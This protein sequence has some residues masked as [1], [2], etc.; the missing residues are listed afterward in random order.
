MI[1]PPLFRSRE[2][3]G[4]SRF[5]ARVF[6]LALA[7]AAVTSSLPLQA[8]AQTPNPSSWTGGSVSYGTLSISQSALRGE[9]SAQ[10]VS[11]SHSLPGYWGFGWEIY[12]CA[13]TTVAPS[14]AAGVP[15]SS[16]CTKI[17][18][19]T[20][21]D[22]GTQ[23]HATLTPSSQMISN[24][25]VVIV[26]YTPGTTEKIWAAWL[27]TTKAA[28]TSTSPSPL[29]ESGL[30]G[31]TV[32][33]T[34][35]HTTY[36]TSGLDKDDFEL[37]SAPDGVTISS[38]SR[39]SGTVAT[40]T[41][42]YDDSNDFDANEKLSVKVLDSGHAG[43]GDLTTAETDVTAVVETAPAAPGGLRATGANLRATLTWNNPQDPSITG[44]EVHRKLASVS[45][46]GSWTAIAGSGAATVTHTVRGLSNG[47][48]YDFQVRALRAKAPPGA[49]SARARAT[50]AAAAPPS[51]TVW[52]GIIPL[53]L[54]FSNAPNEWDVV[55]SSLAASPTSQ[56]IVLEYTGR[57]VRGWNTYV[58][59]ACP[60]RTVSLLTMPQ[61]RPSGCSMIT[62]PAAGHAANRFTATFSP[63]Q[64]MID[65]GG[66]VFVA[67]FDDHPHRYNMYAEWVPVSG[68]A[69]ITKTSPATLGEENLNGATVTVDL[70]GFTFQASVAAGDFELS[71][72]PSGAVVSVSTAARDATEADVA[73]LTLAY[74]GD[75]DEA[76]S[77]GVKAKASG[78]TGSSDLEAG[79]VRVAATV[80][81]A[82]PA[83]ADLVAAAGNASAIL[84]WTDPS[85]TKITGYE[86]QRREAGESWGTTWTAMTGSGAAT[87]RYVVAGLTNGQAYDFRI[88]AL[89]SKAPASEASEAASATPAAATASITAQSADPLTEANIGGATVTVTLERDTYVASGLD[90]D[91]FEL[92]SKPAGVTISSVSRTSGTVAVVTLAF[93]GDFDADA[94]LSVRVLASGLTGSSALTTATIDVTAVLELE[95]SI[96]A[97]SVDPLT[98]ANINEATITVTLTNTTYVASGL[99]EDDFELPSKPTG[100]TINDAIRLSVSDARLWLAFTDDFDADAT[101]SVK[102]LAS[103]H[104]K[105]GDL[106]TGTI[107]VTATVEPAAAKPTELSGRNGNRQVVLS[108]KNPGDETI[109]GYEYQRRESGESWGSWTAMMGSSA[110]TVS[111]AVTGLTNGQGYDF[112][113]RAL[114]TKADPSAASDAISETPTAA[115]ASIT[116]Q[117]P[118][119]EA[120]IGGATVTVTLTG[121]TYV[122]SGLDKNDFELPSKPGG[123]T[124]SAARRSS[125]AAA[126]LT[127]AYDNTDP[128]YDFDTGAKLSVKVLA[129]G[130]AGS[131]NI[132]TAQIDVT[133]VD[134]TAPVAPAGL[135]ATGWNTQVVLRWTNPS[136]ASITSWEYR[137]KLSSESD[138]SEWAAV[139]GSS[140]STTTAIVPNLINGNAYNFQVRAVAA[141]AP[142]GGAGAASAV[143]A[144]P[145]A[146]AVSAFITSPASLTEANLDG[147]TVTV[148]LAG[149]TY[150]AAS[151]LGADDFELASKPAGVTIKAT[152]GVSRSSDTA[153]VLT[154]AYDGTDP[155]YDFDTNEKLSVKVLDSG[156]AGSGNITTAQIDV[157]AVVETAPAAPADLTAAA[158]NFQATL[159]WT[160]PGNANITSWEYSKKLS[161]PSTR[162]WG[163]W[164]AMA[165]SGA[166]TTSYVVRGLSN[167]RAYDFRIRAV[168]AKAPDGGTASAT[169][170]ATPA[171]PAGPSATV[172]RLL[173]SSY[174]PHFHVDTASLAAT[175]SPQS[176]AFRLTSGG[177]WPQVDVYACAQTTVIVNG[178]RDGPVPSGCVLILDGPPNP[179]PNRDGPLTASLTLTQ[180]MIDNGGV[181]FLLRYNWSGWRQNHYAEWVPISAGASITGTSPASPGEGSLNGATVTVD[182]TGL[183]FNSGVAAGDFELS[184]VPSGAVVSV[185]GA[186]RHAT[187]T[188]VAV[189]TL[190][191]T[192]DYDEAFSL[193][194][195]AKAS[196]H[197]G[198]S[199]LKTGTVRVAATV[200]ERPAK[201]SGVTARGV[202]SGVLLKWTNPNNPDITSW[203][204]QQR[205]SGGSYGNTTAMTGSGASTT[206]YVV[207]GLT[208]GSAY[209]F[210]IRA[211][212]AKAP[213][214]G[215]SDWSD[216]VTATAEAE[217]ASIKS[218]TPSSLTEENLDDAE[219]TVE[220][221][222]GLDFDSDVAAADFELSGAPSGVSVSVSAVAWASSEADEAVLTLDYTTTGDFDSDFSLVVKAKATGHTG[223]SDLSAAGVAVA[224][225][226]E[227]APKKPGGLSARNGKWEVVLTWADP[228]NSKITSWQYRKKLSSVTGW[229][230][231]ADVS[232]SSAT[233]TT[234]T[235]TGLTNGTTY[236]FQVRAVAAKAPDGAASITVSGT[237]STVLA[238]LAFTDPRFPTEENLDGAKIEVNLGDSQYVASGLDK[239]DFQLASK[240]PGVTIRDVERSSGTEA[241][242]QLSY[243]GSEFDTDQK[244]SVR[245]LA[246]GHAGTENIVTGETSVTAVVEETP[247]KPTGLTAA[248][249]DGEAVLRWTG[250]ENPKITSWEYRKKLSSGSVWEGW[251][252]VASS[253]ATTRT[254]TVPGLTNGSA[255]DFQVRALRTK[256]PAAGIASD[257]AT[258]TPTAPGAAISS[259]DPS[260]LTEE[261][262][263]GAEVT[264]SLSNTTYV[265][266]GTLV[267][268]HFELP[269]K[270]TGVTISGV[271]RS[272]DTAAVVTLAYDGTDF[273][274]D[275]KLSVKVLAAG[276]AKTGDLT[277]PEVDVTAAAGAEVNGVS[278]TSTPSGGSSGDTYGPGEEIR[279][280]VSFTD[281]RLRVT[282]ATSEG[283]PYVELGVGSA[284]RRAVYDSSASS[285]GRLAFGYTVQSGDSDANGISIGSGALKANT[286]SIGTGRGPR[287]TPAGLSLLG[288]AVSDDSDHKVDGSLSVPAKPTVLSASAGVGEAVL[289]WTDPSDSGITGW[290]Y[291][292][293]SDGG[294]WSLWKAVTGGIA[295]TTSATVDGLTGGES[296]SFQVRAKNGDGAS[297]ASDATSSVT[298]LGMAIT[299][300][301]SPLAEHPVTLMD[302]AKITVTLKGAIEFNSSLAVGDFELVTDV[303]G[304]TISGAE[305][306][307]G[308]TKAAELTLAYD[309]TDFETDRKVSVKVKGS[310][311]G[312]TAE[313]TTTTEFPVTATDEAPP[314]AITG[315][316][317]YPRDGVVVLTWT[318][319]SDTA[320]SYEYRHRKT[321]DSWPASW[322]ALAR[323]ASNT[324]RV[325][326]L[327]N[328]SAYE[329]EFR[330]VTDRGGAGASVSVTAT[331]NPVSATITGTSPATVTD[332]DLDGATVTVGVTGT[333]FNSSITK[334]DFEVSGITGLGIKASGGVNRSSDTEAVL[335]LAYSGTGLSADGAFTVKVAHGSHL[336]G[337]NLTAGTVTVRAVPE[338]SGVSFTG[339]PP[340]NSTWRRGEKIVVDVEFSPGVTV[341]GTPQLGLGIGSNTRQAAYESSGS[342]ST[343]LRFGYVVQ[344]ADED[345]DG[346][347]IAATALGL[348]GGSIVHSGAS[349]VNAALG[350]GTH[351]VTDDSDHKVDGSIAAYAI[352]VSPSGSLTLDEGGSG[353]T[354]DVNL[355]LQPVIDVVVDVSSD[356]ADV[357]VSKDGGTTKSSSVML[358][359]NT[360]SWNTAQ[361][362]TVYAGED[363][364]AGDDSATL[365]Y[366]VVAES[367][368]D[369]YDSAPD[370]TRAV[371]VTDDDE[372][373][374][375]TSKSSA[376][377]NESGSGNSFTYNVKL[378]SEPTGNVTVTPASSPAGLVTV[379][380]SRSDN[381]L[382]FTTTDWD[383][384]QEVTVTAVDNDV[385]DA[386]DRT[387]SVTHSVSG[388][389]YAT[390]ETLDS[391]SVT[392]TDKDTA[393][394]EVSAVSGQATEDGGTATFT[395][396]LATQP[397]AAVTM[398]VTSGDTG[399]GTVSPATLTFEVDDNNG[400]I[401]SDTQEVTVT[402]VDD[403]LVDGTQTYDITLGSPTSTDSKYSGL[404]S[405]TVS[406]TTTDDD[407]PAVVVSAVSGQA[408]EAGGTATFTVRLATQPTAAVTI[409]VSSGD[410]GEGTVSP[411]TLTFETDDTNSRIW[412]T[413]QTVTVTG[414]DDSLDDGDQS[415]D[416]TLGSPTSTDTGYSGLSAQTVSVTT[417][418]D[419]TAAVEVSVVS[420]Q[421]TEAGGT[422][423]FTVKLGSEPTADVTIAVSSGDVGEG[424]V[425]PA[426]LTFETDNTNSKIWSAAQTVTVTGIDDSLDDGD[427]SYDITLGSPTSTDAG[428]SGLSAQTVSVTTTDDDTAAVVVSAVSGQATEAGG[429]ATFTVK[430][431]S[432]PTADV[433]ITV[434][435]GDVGE[436]TVLPATLTFET[437]NDNSKIWSTAQT[438]TVTG[439]DD[440]LDDGDQSYDITLG[441]PTSSDAGY[442]GLSA[443]TVSVTT[444]DDDTAAVEV[445]AVSGQATEAGGTATFTVKLGSEP[446]ADVTIAVSSGDVGEG[447]VSPATLT[448]ETDDTNSRIWS[449]AQTVT[450]TG[451]DD[452]LDDGDRSYDITLGSPTST[453]TGYS[454]LSAQTVSVTTTDDDTAAVEVSAV[455]GQAT[456]AGGTATFTVKLGSEPA[457]NVTIAVSSGDVGEGTVSPA[458]L[459]FETDNTNSKIWSAAQT[460]TVTGVDDSLADGPQ[461]YDVT[462]GSPTSTDA[463][464][465]GLLA[466][467]VSVTTTDDDT[468]AVEVSAVSGQA[469]EAGGTATFTVKL[470]TQPTAD[471]TIA[472]SSGDVGEGTVSPATLTFETDDTNS[473]IWSTAQ[474]VTVT[475]VDD[476]LDDG[477]QSY[478]ITLGSPT[479]TDAGYSGL[480]AQTVSVTT[481]DD[482][483][484]AVEVSVVSGQATEAGGTATFTVKLGSEP[485]ADVTIAVSSGDVGEGTVSPATLT[486]ET[487]N[488]NSKIWSAAQTVTVTGIDDS[489]DD[490]DQSYDI[491]LGSPTST[492]TGYS[493]LSAQTVSVT[494]TDDDTAAVEVSVV[495]GQ[496]TEA[497][498]TATFTV[499]LGSE[500]TADVTIAVSSGDVGEGTVSP[501]TLTFETDATNSK[502]WSTAQT[503]TVT[504]IDDGVDD[505]DQNYDIT[506]GSP[507]STD[508]GYSGLSAQTVSVT[509]TDD[510]TAALVVSVVSGQATEAGGTATFTVKLGSEPTADVTI[511]VSSGDVGEGTVS[512][513][514][515]TFETDDTN[516]RIWST[517]QTVTV[518]GIDDGV[519]DGDQSYDITLGSPT[520]TDTGYSGLSAQTVSVTTTD[521]D[522]AAVEVSAVSGQATEAGGTATFTVKLGSEPTANV[523]IAVSS[524]DVG[525]GTV[526]PA[527][528]TFETDNTNSK[529]WSAAQTVTVTG[530]DDSLADGPQTY[531]VTLGSPTSTDTGYSG[532]SAKT[533]SVTTTDDDTPAVEVSAVSG[534]ATEAGGTAT[535]TVKLA[536]Q[537]TANVTIAVTSGDVGEGT[538]SP[539]TLTF[540]TDDT[541]NKIWSTAQTVTVTGVDDSLDD[542][543]QSY[544]V[545]LGSP[546][547]S[548]AGY[549]GLSSQ[550]VS[551]TTTDDDT[552]A[553]D[554]SAVSGQATE[555]GGTATFTVKLATQPTA[556]VTIAV[557]SGDTTEGAVSPA[558]LT[559]TPSGTGIW[560][561]AQTVTVTGVDDSLDDGNQSYDITL[562]SP[563]STD[564][565]YSGLSA[566]TVSVTTT[567]DDTAAV[568]VSVVSGQ[569][570]EAG[571]TATFT[572]KLATRPTANVAI[573][574]SSGDTGE[575]TVSP[576]TLTFETDDT[577]SKIWSTAQTVTVTGVDD[578]LDDGNQSYDIT[579]GS[580]TSTDTGYSGLSAQ[581]VSVTTTDDDTAAVEVSVVS[582]Q[583]TEAGGTAT[584]TVKLATRPTANVAIAVSSGDTGE[585]TVSPATL[586]FRPTGSTELWS[587][588]QTVTVTG[589]DD[590]LDD[591][592]QSYD[593]TLGS[594]TSTDAGYSGLS[595]QT[596]SVTT[597]DDDT[598]AV[599]V[600]AVSGQATEAGGTATFTV[601]LATRPTANVTIAVSSGDTTE[602]AVS[603]ATL[604]F[605]PSGAGI[606]STAQTVTVTGVDD[607][608]ADGD[609]T[610]DVTVGSPTGSDTGYSGLSAQTV[611]V[612]T[613]DD[614]TPAVVVS[615]VSGQATE[616]G[617]TATFT[618]KLATQPTANVRIAV[619]SGD[620]TEG[621]VSPATLTFTPSGAG[622]WSTAQTVTVTGVDDSLDDGTQTYNVT[623]ASP[624]STDTGYS[625]LSAQ[626]VSV[627]T[628]DDDTAAVEVSVVSGQATEAGGTA[629]FTVKL[630][631]RPTAN[632]AI[633]VS[634][635][636]TTEG[637]VSPAT[638]TFRPTGSTELW[639]TA[640]TVTV[641]G[642]DDSLDDGT[643][644]YDIT[645]GSPTGSDAGYSGLSAQTVS[646][647]TT[648]D[649]TAA[650]EVSVVS[651]QATE[652]GGTATFTVKLATR[653]T[654]NVT[655]AVSSGDVGEGT[656]S[657]A[658]LTF[659]TD[660][661]NSKIWS[662]AQ[663]V[664][665]TGVDDSLDDGDQTYNVTVGSPTSSDTDYSALSAQTVSVT[666]TD[667]DAAAVEVSAVS[668]QATE[669]GGAATFTVKLATQPTANVTIAVSSGDTGEGTVS[670]ATLTFETDDTNNKIWST[671]Q[672]VTVTGVDDSLDDGN[673]SYD[674]TLGSPTS[675]DTGYSG[676]SAQTV[677]VTTTDD[678]AAAVVV[679]AVSG[680]ATEAGGT[681]TFTVKLA[682]QPTANV[683]I[684]VS[685][686][687]TGEGTVSPAT[688]TFRPTGST[689]LWSTAQTVTVTGVDDSLDD[690]TQT[691]D[692]T[693]AS[694]TGSDA[695]YSALSAQTVSVTTTDDDAAAVVVSAVSGQ[696]TEAGGAA[697]FTVKLA[698]R[699][700][701]NVAIAVSSGDTTEGTVSPAT[702]TFRPTGSTELWSTA[703]TVTV[704]GVDDSLDDG[705]Q[706]YDITV[707]SPTGSDTDYSALSSQTVSVTT[708]DDDTAAVVVS[709]VSGQAA[710]AGGTATFTVKLATQPTANVAIAVSSG[711]T[712]EGTVSPA[713]LTFRPTG[714]TELW[715]TAQTVT[716]TG[717]DD[718][719]D[720][721]NQTYDVTLASPTGSDTDYSAL[722]SQTVS[723]TTT[724]DDAAAVEVSAVSGQATEA[725]GTATF[726][727]KLATQPTA[728][729]TIAVSSGDTGEGAVSPATL[730]FTPSGTGIWSTAQTVTVTGE[731]DS[732]DDGTQTYDITLGSPTSTD[733]DYSA[734]SSQT[735][736]VTTTDDDTA[737]VTVSKSSVSVTEEGAAGDYTVVLT[738]QPSANVTV[739][740]SSG[741]AAKV[742]V[743]TGT[744]T[745]S[746]SITL[747]FTPSGTGIWSTAQTVTVTAED[748]SDSQDE[749]VTLTQS[750]GSG[751]ASEYSS[752]SVSNVNVQVTDND[753]P[754]IEV[755]QTGALALAEGASGT[756]N[757]RLT[758]QP[759]SDVVVSITSDNT[760]VTVKTGTGTASGSLTL[761]FTQ[762]NWNTNQEVTVAAGEDTDSL[763][764][765][766][767]ITHAV[768][769]G[770]SSSEYHAV[771]DRMFT[772]NVTD[773]DYAGLSIAAAEASESAGTLDFTVTKSMESSRTVTVDWALAAGTAT[774]GTSTTGDYDATTATG[775]LTFSAGET[776]KTISVPINDDFLVEGDETVT[777]TLSNQSPS[778][779]TISGSPAT[780]TIKDDDAA[781]ASVTPER[782]LR[783]TT[784]D[785]AGTVQLGV[786]LSSKPAWDVTV[787]VTSSDTT[788]GI[789]KAAEDDPDPTLTFEPDDTNGRIWST[790]QTVTVTGVDDEDLDGDVEY[791]IKLAF[792][793]ADTDYRDLSVDIPFTNLDDDL[794]I[795]SISGG[796]EV[797]E[798]DTG[799]SVQ[800][801][802]TVSLA[803]ARRQEV[804]VSYATADGTA[805]AGSDYV[806]ASG[807]VTFSPGEISRTVAVT[808]NGDDE[809]EA[810]ETFSVTLTGTPDGQIDSQNSSAEAVIVN[811]DEKMVDA[812]M[813]GEFSVGDTTVTVDSTIPA[814]TGLEVVLPSELESGG[815]VIEE[816]TVTLGPTD[817][818]IDADLFGYTGTDDDHVLVDID[819]SPVPDAA[820]RVCLP[821]TDGLRRAAGEQRLYLIRFSGGSW[822]ELSS[823]TKGNMV[824]ADVNGF[825]P[826]ALV[827]QIDF[828]KRRF[829]E[830]NRAI[831]PELARA[832]TSSA[833][834][835]ITARIEAAMSGGADVNS[836]NAQ[837]PHEEEYGH[838][839][840]A[841]RLGEFEDGETLS[842]LDSI[843]GSRFSV[844]LAGGYDPEEGAEQS[845]GSRS[846]G[847]GMWISGDYRNLSGKSGG[848]VDW[849]GR[850]VSGHL[851]A[852]YRFGQSF[853]AGV[854]TSWSQGSFDY[855]GRGDGTR[856][857]GDYGSR[858]NSF[859]PYLGL[860]LSRRLGVWAAG[861][862]GF[863]EIRI[864]DGEVSGRRRASTRLGTLATGADLQLLGS[865]A[866]T[867]SLKG[868]AWISRMKVKDNGG[869][870]E[871]LR[872]GTNRLRATLEGSHA[873][874]FGSG[875]SLIPSLE[876][877]IRRDGGDGETG[878]GGELGGGIVY[879]SSF[880][881]AV[882]AR[883]RTLLFHQGDTKEWGLGGS[884][885]FNPGG[886]GR[887]LSMSVLP[888]Y[889]NS[890]SGVQGLWESEKVADLGASG[891]TREFGLETEVGYGFPMFGDGGLLTPY[892]AF[893]RPD[894][895]SRNYRF[896]GRFSM[897]RTIDLTLEGQRRELRAGAPEHELTLQGRLNW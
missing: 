6:L 359:F 328:G 652:A 289:R 290:E 309:G 389:D 300:S 573:A 760:D 8:S 391:V 626:T 633:A 572:V 466:K 424:T 198:T 105:T 179:S 15:P 881:L 420:G 260:S 842:L 224:A 219:L 171:A 570:T 318:H 608:L 36:V 852:D 9:S 161:S 804:S 640:Q 812:S 807:T 549:S 732:L 680:Q 427:Q 675:T 338:V 400:K 354:Y 565:G 122:T 271:S 780:G 836:L 85:D 622:I 395:V 887:G 192:G 730:T 895:D 790:A 735:V 861:G 593:I 69:A 172:W 231:W 839:E 771:V 775:T 386:S 347:S 650:V 241:V 220:L 154:L 800:A 738:T 191:Y 302:G 794:S 156:H 120:N 39:T 188:D 531:D 811:D 859:H 707:G 215:G 823:T 568:E 803:P 471:V 507:T 113:I 334:D 411:A 142:G 874:A 321:A 121:A 264:V 873:L 423:T 787:T 299:V 642:V 293:K 312:G 822:E 3:G 305:R 421:A 43:S 282:L 628:T 654:A 604:T 711:D 496:A 99:D 66:F 193:G 167:G 597:T 1:P 222:G 695:G 202:S 262:L 589:V 102:V 261:T 715:S 158:G 263:D 135:T 555:A 206:S 151:S 145:A 272:S 592:N 744:G 741:D 629:T 410:V 307:T 560:S 610:Y 177:H 64:A 719:L 542:G 539:A 819:V 456:E 254:V 197:T 51:S 377:I 216:S 540:E 690:E 521:D 223:S 617:G 63:T 595:A 667:D 755:S 430:L 244:I 554:V 277:T 342:T 584:F 494:T 643:Q 323:A 332:G 844:S 452:S 649:D 37:A 457:A 372:E 615:A 717:V 387:G 515:L 141:K 753:A 535:F 351:A 733:T 209:D 358:T 659:E 827:Y 214:G 512:P 538:V 562:D 357:T 853:L 314:D 201:P 678:D 520:S 48:A 23:V 489:L 355:S 236:D 436:G 54:P 30:D 150:V 563:T 614:D 815:A 465:S 29:T 90:K 442:S 870:I 523:T 706:T 415:Y 461:T 61:A 16:E 603:P 169:A 863:G 17:Y 871:G 481:T 503:V 664:T 616:A 802:F 862:W 360:N 194:V 281:P 747:T 283:K 58:L 746:G 694:P 350:L 552:A 578:S 576:A 785:N 274:A 703:Q 792:D 12:A 710:E 701:A 784:E 754:N 872:V 557:S 437:D 762:S 313:L 479:S 258:T 498:G 651:G 149:S 407:A 361:T 136:N 87:V 831:L 658:T 119:T 748:D 583:A 162:D 317:G 5:L 818:E 469:T 876:F 382:V 709:A 297:E 53:N 856:V 337:G 393:A 537:P 529:I 625:A 106:T 683:A 824:C 28:I 581:T 522:T 721:G 112:R 817:E 681:A 783:S 89:R 406:V 178:N 13:R 484:A 588:A 255:Y 882:E 98:E 810:N 793:S 757:V 311:Y 284:T 718:S 808:V 189:L 506:L 404:S 722:S 879:A 556:N 111:Y 343:R 665:V 518:T 146:G 301:P 4:L 248:G 26:V 38:A 455:S 364:D 49:A 371:S 238:I 696:A 585:G 566:Q 641:T 727:V 445:S 77:L 315:F 144:T 551:V 835:A 645:L 60:V 559:F 832:M 816:L 676:L 394:V 893:G 888:T 451:I 449:T 574:V 778:E 561:T 662:T 826:F 657:P 367:S 476:S 759:A 402:G 653:P 2:R 743:N 242:L 758:T 133:A 413:A 564:T 226:D 766:A 768:V 700:T 227:E 268:T 108:W 786:A 772:V 183:T 275:E 129:S 56:S 513:A 348:N 22:T 798:G 166:S 195:T 285:R 55:T 31:A 204:Y 440:S 686:G 546:T 329:F 770:S 320:I 453:D 378:K 340:V 408:T 567:D 44:Y 708:T 230:A 841:L 892:G 594:P 609:Q 477:N 896:G 401:W 279:V 101:L 553:V 403:S 482:D 723:V 548:D 855:T 460:V 791:N 291:R 691:Y 674:I 468:P 849:D 446:T 433:T 764:E 639:S 331:P 620:T 833:L 495:S 399:E 756:Y 175:L 72:A 383:V 860:S 607:S 509:T 94:T 601:K 797:T 65:N 83:P 210:Q 648:D 868:E 830:V 682:T 217:G 173:G 132:T 100:V 814:D 431:G 245:V 671:A 580:P 677:S 287:V 200:E 867:L 777:V 875:S 487:D 253:S 170:S 126:V 397:T 705:T 134:E 417:T 602:G 656:V 199:D 34:L 164:M 375:T 104:A 434:S 878:V 618:V 619:S 346:V 736:S 731:D 45:G 880:G 252:A 381:T 365:T 679:S 428:Y 525:E 128:D 750:I 885:S 661:T 418:D 637:A 511:A 530:V 767:K 196:G 492:D 95:A 335:T 240:P 857:S 897:N 740:I 699:P 14:T 635:G 319:P 729:V 519:D 450:V 845:P 697:T 577:N 221:A 475:G 796:G 435:S 11:V 524:G 159:T 41:L 621:T 688:L 270:P 689:E 782:S 295:T 840:P 390:G 500:P 517:A 526:S 850:L 92:A 18:T 547:S 454:G 726:T 486:F 25:G 789:V 308:N 854:A 684:A 769:D 795:L 663:T 864:D 86:Y 714:S 7:L 459:T 32:T 266:E 79:T 834:E 225:T 247:A 624:T 725:G 685:S 374:V 127:L 333:T 599:E 165:G 412:S 734:L 288:F 292:Y 467:T 416:I 713:T 579:L 93:T 821:V 828:I 116:V 148:A 837:S 779:V 441:S 485:T 632:V 115:T 716:V 781:G 76:F 339:T 587:T 528:L 590:S 185:T 327:D 742:K 392:L 480:S 278:I 749:T 666:T 123:V 533:V 114:R 409:A 647:T 866:T 606:W 646:V 10:T 232:S 499:K 369:E 846:G 380:T 35:S 575:G 728:D 84:S 239:A 81:T 324:H 514:T 363:D 462:L 117:S 623:L 472:V 103:G 398:T 352:S 147:A 373:G 891:S 52:R 444:T 213:A 752:V 448:F 773:N 669:A 138:W 809:A 660:D 181:V 527:T 107:A 344:S 497:G 203:E 237:P 569:A 739:S 326:G 630:A 234:V 322:T 233:T 890:S 627:T 157:T 160:D 218:T 763:D 698:T 212:V 582:G 419:D 439:V 858:M 458:T 851:G 20:S 353:G 388:A 62:G 478:D 130:H 96:S 19:G 470:A 251:V 366:S 250:P 720:D 600:S 894:P 40:V 865:G 571:G 636:D 504:G 751:S 269:S 737:G 843:E 613:T 57:S 550:T 820:V 70:T 501:A 463:G 257:T 464:Y 422:A 491:T 80:E 426:T 74:T 356:N 110:S 182:L 384:D 341:T 558:T 276:H 303:P 125:A 259:T 536:T 82:A 137:Y 848:L 692:V 184:G 483:T 712:T 336:R 187:E 687:D 532:L 24:G 508:T 304:L 109:T 541:N 396:K 774:A 46:Y 139:S 693:L 71:G 644:T 516:S 405:Q 267:K 78:H 155:D 493:G 21:S 668:G 75:Y 510:D 330:G 207:R 211:V 205:S 296:Y 672:T 153:A 325:S 799:S 591:G 490:G 176:V 163:P 545:T 265:A 306:K 310:A 91:D 286:A 605:T 704:T 180:A 801:V 235:V 368:S 362:I 131:G 294:Q 473:R 829:G 447:T 246:S 143:S 813:S 869:R 761:T 598:A 425:S 124:I 474:T 68:S 385:D 88:R 59:L 376:T 118:L 152:G 534:Q 140:A 186:A 298:I 745:A 847:L 229:D 702:L 776:S 825:S 655:I 97:Q 73:V 67:H 414:I 505:G 349:G 47:L 877:G 596:V 174:A 316:A 42:A 168:V 612:T 634:S 838:I 208:N 50:P 544:D 27:P 806:A 673:Q 249:G 788:E 280:E 638:L 886:D 190:S 502:I 429:T 670:P 243:D 345:T 432:E 543:D 805:E 273:D 765:S 586:T 884:V 883:G 370:V 228:G 438:V 889:G 33:V 724:D 488:D 611:R 443:Q 379:T 631:T 256:A